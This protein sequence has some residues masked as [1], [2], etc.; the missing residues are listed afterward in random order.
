M[1]TGTWRVKDYEIHIRD[2]RN[3]DPPSLRGR[4]K[5]GRGDGEKREKEKERQIQIKI[6]LREVCEPARLSNPH[7]PFFSLKLLETKPP[8]G[9][10]VTSS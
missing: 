10:Y 5:Q 2:I 1:P 7:K 8:L 3:P 4:R 6:D 9:R